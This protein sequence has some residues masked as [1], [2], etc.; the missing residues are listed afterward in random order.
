VA[1][2]KRRRKVKKRDGSSRGA[3]KAGS[4]Q[5]PQ[6]LGSVGLW[7]ALALALITLVVYGQVITHRF[8][9]FD[10]DTYIWAN[11]MV[12]AG[13]TSKGLVWAFTTFHSANWHP[14]TW[15]S[16]MA[17]SQLFGLNAGG[18]LIVNAL[19]HT[20]NAVLLFWFLSRV[21]RATWQSAIIAA[22]FAL[23]PLHVESVAWASERKDTLS[24][25]FG[26]LCL[27]AYSR[28]VSEP[29]WKRYGAVAGCLA[30]GLM[31]KPMLV[32]WPFVLLLLDYWPFGR[33]ALRPAISE[34]RRA[35]HV[36][37]TERSKTARPSGARFGAT[38]KELAVA[39][40]PLIREKLPL[41]FLVV[42][43]MFV[44]YVAQARGGAVSGLTI[45]P[46]SWRLAN[47]L[48]SYVKYLFLA[49]W[50]RDLAIYYPS[51]HDSIP[52]WEWG[53]A[54]IL[55]G[56]V[57]FFVVKNARKLPYLIVGWLWFVGTLLPVIGL[58]RVGGQAMADRYTYV[59]SIGLFIALVFGFSDL[60]AVSRLRRLLIV[61]VPGI[62]ISVLA[63]LSALQISRWRDSETLFRYVLSINS[64]NAVAQ[65]NLGS[66]LGEKRKPA[67]ALPHFAEA[68]R[69]APR[70]FDALGN[71][72]QVLWEQG[73]AAQAVRY[74][75]RALEVRPDSAKTHWQ[76]GLALES[77][78]QT[79]E[80]MQQFHEAVRSAPRDSAMHINL[81]M[82]LA[83]QRKLAE[84]VEQYQQALRLDPN[85]AEAHNNLGLVLFALGRE[86]EGVREFSTA[87][88]LK[89]ELA[90]A[91]DNLTRAQETMAR[92]Q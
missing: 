72:G 35:R 11:P 64:G 21:T 78:R 4:T 51:F 76:L 80:A 10:D 41:F 88:R 74:F 62:A 50:P 63:G 60:V 19:L 9:N 81:G 28:Y 77:L 27:L 31:T 49:F 48:L 82:K 69:L 73:E 53:L 42:P 91:R 25:A 70:Y 37:D 90:V 2:R 75:E 36:E 17:D 39:F 24:T 61:L 54:L 56:T 71:M 55:L 58:V 68:L 33:V 89:P 92:R 38:F 29:S 16:H 20:A 34:G 84:A 57:S 83:E 47:A 44:T 3:K 7:I 15:L 52:I 87:V 32:T 18:H 66:A 85:I 67:E 14:L 40:W 30:L 79:V 1:A 23:H 26:L 46:L 22:L 5:T 43:S 45:E 12:V 8:I 13:L 6:G 59:P 65:N 86:E